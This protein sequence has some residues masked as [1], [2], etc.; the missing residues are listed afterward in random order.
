[1]SG[2]CPKRKFSFF[3]SVGLPPESFDCAAMEAATPGCCLRLHVSDH[4]LIPDF[5][6]SSL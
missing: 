1:M 2:L 6:L 3:N 5:I 4:Q